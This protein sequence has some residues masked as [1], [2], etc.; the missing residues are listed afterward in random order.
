MFYKNIKSLPKTRKFT[1]AHYF[2]EERY[3]ENK[4][5]AHANYKNIYVRFFSVKKCSQKFTLL[6][7]S[8]IPK[9]ISFALFT[10]S[11][12]VCILYIYVTHRHYST[13]ARI[14]FRISCV[15]WCFCCAAHV[16]IIKSIVFYI[17]FST[18]RRRRRRGAYN[19]AKCAVVVVK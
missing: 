10:I 12:Y 15:A 17:F 4:Q 8:Y 9:L 13:L 11:I 7:Y 6:V 1:I 19:N 2:R 3:I 14:C 5:T 18:A 16:F